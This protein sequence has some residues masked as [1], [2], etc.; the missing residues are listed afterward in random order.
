M[1]TTILIV[2]INEFILQ[3]YRKANKA[4]LFRPKPFSFDWPVTM[5]DEL[6][7]EIQIADAFLNLDETDYDHFSLFFSGHRSDGLG[8]A[9]R[10]SAPVRL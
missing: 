8:F 6:S 3:N 10:H 7:F 1:N 2:S 4:I 5:K 9:Q